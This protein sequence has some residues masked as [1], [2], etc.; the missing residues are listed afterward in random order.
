MGFI[1]SPAAD[2]ENAANELHSLAVSPDAEPVT[3]RICPGSHECK[4][5]LAAT[6]DLAKA[7]IAVMP[8]KSRGLVWALSGC[9]NSCVQPQLADVGIVSSRLVTNEQG[10]KA[11]LFD[12]YRRH[13]AGLGEKLQSQLT[14]DELT[15][16]VR[17]I[18]A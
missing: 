16:A 8:E 17:G 11:P 10:G 15:D 2:R 3:F 12:L 7:L 4:M 14:I 1:L 13:C 18:A 5:G 6:R 9:P